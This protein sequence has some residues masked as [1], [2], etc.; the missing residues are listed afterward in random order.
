MDMFS[1][2]DSINVLLLLF[3]ITSFYEF[4]YGKMF[5]KMVHILT[6]EALKTLQCPSIF[7]VHKIKFRVA[8]FTDVS[9]LFRD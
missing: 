5:S 3:F 2:F 7:F 8:Y 1:L 9:T 6:I 4:I